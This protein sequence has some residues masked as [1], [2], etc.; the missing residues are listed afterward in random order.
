MIVQWM[1][2]LGMFVIPMNT[3]SAKFRKSGQGGHGILR[4][5]TFK[6]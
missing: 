1:K 3:I 5:V 4:T 2:K 6:F